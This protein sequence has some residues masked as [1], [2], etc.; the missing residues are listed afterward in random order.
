MMAEHNYH[1]G[2]L[3]RAV[4]RAAAEVI[5][6]S[7]PLAVN[8]RDLARRVGVSHAAPAHHFGD[9]TGLLTALA[10]EGFELLADALGAARSTTDIYELGTA[11]VTFALEHYAHLDVMF[12]PSLYRSDD[13]ALVESQARAYA[14]LR[15]AVE[16]L[17]VTRRG[18]DLARA[19]IGAWSLAHG[20]AALWSQQIL[21]SELGSSP[22]EAFRAISR[23]IFGA[24]S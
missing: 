23:F 12:Q 1:H 9:K 7:G 11:Y 17:P 10:A 4:L 2:D 22:D 20:F 21:P 16:E 14:A 3:R 8:L 13:P 19:M 5:D 18:D 6:E 24:D 15:D